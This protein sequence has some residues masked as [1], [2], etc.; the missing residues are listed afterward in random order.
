MMVRAMIAAS[1]QES[2]NRNKR[3]RFFMTGDL[4]GSTSESGDIPA[5]DP[6][7]NW[8]RD[9]RGRFVFGSPAGPGRPRGARNKLANAFLDALYGDFLRHGRAAIE[10]TRR[11]KPEAYLRIVALLLPKDVSVKVSDYD[12]LSDVELDCRIASLIRAL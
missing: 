7:T 8:E 5:D 12:A 1:A 3:N 9:E 6:V 11:E 10:E 4:F 2:P